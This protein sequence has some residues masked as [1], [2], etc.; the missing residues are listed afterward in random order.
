M[1]HRKEASSN[2]VESGIQLAILES[3]Q[4]IN[5]IKNKLIK[6]K[7]FP[8]NT[9]KHAGIIASF[10]LWLFE[11][12]N[13]IAFAKSSDLNTLKTKL[14]KGKSNLK[15]FVSKFYAEKYTTS[16]KKEMDVERAR[17]QRLENIILQ[18]N[19]EKAFL[20]DSINIP[21]EERKKKRTVNNIES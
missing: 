2:S 18:R 16:L 4:K 17:L 10:Y 6:I 13:H 5:E 12:I 11:H 8:E 1:L 15:N 7:V 19:S 20:G 3:K 9:T 21:E 14:E